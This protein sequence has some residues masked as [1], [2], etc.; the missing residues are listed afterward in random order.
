VR[1]DDEGSRWLDLENLN[2][3]CVAFDRPVN[4]DR[5]RLRIDIWP[6]QYGRGKI[7]S[8]RDARLKGVFCVYVDSIARVDRGNRFSVGTEDIR[9][10][11]RSDLS[12]LVT[13]EC[14]LSPHSQRTRTA[15]KL[16]ILYRFH[17]IFVIRL[18]T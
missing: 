16:V 1:A 12:N 11:L 9:I 14:L 17:G 7:C 3:E 2:D 4:L 13:P 15:H 18:F 5:P 8:T 6:F 10:R